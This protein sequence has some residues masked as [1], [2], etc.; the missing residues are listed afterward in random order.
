MTTTNQSG[1]LTIE[2]DSIS[3]T[4]PQQEGWRVPVSELRLIG[5]FTNDHGPTLDDYFFVFLTREEYFEASF[6]ADGRDAVLAELSRR[7][8]HELRNGLCNSTSLASRVLW[9]VRLEGLPLFSLVPEERAGS[10]L[11]RLRQ[12]LVPRVHMK[13]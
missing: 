13:S 11:G 2:P 10:V 5:E 9:P 4:L 1:R 8:Q 7:L 6:Y 3:Y 12:R